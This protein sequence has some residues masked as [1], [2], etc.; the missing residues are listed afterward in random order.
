MTVVNVQLTHDSNPSANMQP[1]HTQCPTST[2][3]SITHPHTSFEQAKQIIMNIDALL[4][5]STVQN[6]ILQELNLHDLCK[7]SSTQQ[8]YLYENSD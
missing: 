1:S 2:I 3:N 5:S 8:A 6:K 7:Y 4:H